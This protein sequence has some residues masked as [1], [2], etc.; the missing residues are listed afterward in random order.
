[1][2]PRTFFKNFTR[3][4]G[5]PITVEYQMD[6][7]TCASILTAWPNTAE[8]NDLCARRLELATDNYG[9]ELSPI[10]ISMMD[11]DGREELEEIA[12]SIERHDADSI[13]TDAER[14]RMERWLSENYIQESDIEF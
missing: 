7:A 2:M 9:R 12:K 13:L 6:D 1:M 10:A 3:D 5:Q 11:A 4:N 14:E 8:Y